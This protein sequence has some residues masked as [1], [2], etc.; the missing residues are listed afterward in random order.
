MVY[1]SARVIGNSGNNTSQRC[2]AVVIVLVSGGELRIGRG[3]WYERPISIPS[4]RGNF[5]ELIRRFDRSKGEEQRK[6]RVP[7]L[8]EWPA[9][10]AD[11]LRNWILKSR[12]TS[13]YYVLHDSLLH[14]FKFI[15]TDGEIIRE[16]RPKFV[17][18]TKLDS[19]TEKNDFSD[20]R[21]RVIYFTFLRSVRKIISH[22]NLANRYAYTRTPGYIFLSIPLIASPVHGRNG[23]TP[24]ETE[25]RLT[26]ACG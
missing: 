23:A 3:L 20:P 13:S 24:S 5:H 26:N 15:H 1:G 14:R 6:F 7:S 12:E 19:T 11:E 2:C 22:A 18:A 17:M 21:L 8:R 4:S 16:H 25:I 10:I 9:W